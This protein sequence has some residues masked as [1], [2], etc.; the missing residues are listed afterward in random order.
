M[1]STKR[2]KQLRIK[3]ISLGNAEVG[4]SCIIKRYCEKRFVQKY[5]QTIGIDYGVTR[6]NSIKDYDIKCNI[7]DMSGHPIFYEVRNEFYKDTQG[8]LLVFDVN[9]KQSFDSL[10]E[11]ITEVK[12][13]LG[14]SNADNIVFVVC[15]NKI[16]KQGGKRMVSESDAKL[17][18]SL[19][20]Y[21]YFEVSASSGSGIQEMFDCLFN[22][23]IKAIENGGKPLSA[24]TNL[25]YNK[26]QI[27]AIQRLKASKDN[28]ERLG[29]RPGCSKEEINNAY[30]KLA[31]KFH[32]DKNVAPGSEEA[33]KILL[34]ART[35]LLK[36]F[37]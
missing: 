7:F 9:D 22:Q 13:E 21:H 11:W 37:N 32:P 8:A 1:T 28:Y 30:K 25:G 17:W 33:F 26:E 15:G 18:S 35:E 24:F 14:D 20:G 29:L 4:K 27:E 5:L 34:N 36:Q 6:V 23:I 2:S 10:D 12:Q 16:D 19:K 3:I 31:I